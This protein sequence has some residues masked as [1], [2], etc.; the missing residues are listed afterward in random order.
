[1]T[2]FQ[3]G[4]ML[5]LR[6]AMGWLFF[7]AGYVQLIAEKWS[8]EGYLKGAKNFQEL[9]F[10]LLRP[11]ILPIISQVN[12]WALI[13]LGVSLI[14]GAFVRLSAYFGIVLM[15]LYYFVLPFPAQS[16]HGLVVDE[17]IIYVGVLAVLAALRAGRF[18]GMD[19][20][21][22]TRFG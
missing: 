14:F 10:W 2:G 12:K 19:S 8:A 4:A 5:F 22:R 21:L 20:L 9:Y 15:L 7:Y 13:L 1:M 3:K 18:I 16:T 11:E 17:H 6:L